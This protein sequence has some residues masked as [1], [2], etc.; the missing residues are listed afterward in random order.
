MKLNNHQGL[1]I[2][3]CLLVSMSLICQISNYFFPKKKQCVG[4]CLMEKIMLEKFNDNKSYKKFNTIKY[5]DLDECIGL[6]CSKIMNESHPDIP[7]N[8]YKRCKGQMQGQRKKLLKD[9]LSPD[10][11]KILYLTM[12][13]LSGDEAITRGNESIIR[14][15][16]NQ[17]S[18]NPGTTIPQTTLSGTTI[19]QTTLS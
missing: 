12:Y 15:V 6:P 2:G 18:S 10:D 19:P 16:R 14:G 17:N 13:T 9:R 11:L 5:L 4:K 8:V 3:L 1:L 7:C